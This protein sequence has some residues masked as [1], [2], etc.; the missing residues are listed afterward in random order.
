[1]Q[2]LCGACVLVIKVKSAC[3]LS[4]ADSP[5]LASARPVPNARYLAPNRADHFLRQP[6]DEVRR[7]QR[8]LARGARAPRPAREEFNF[9]C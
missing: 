9:D 5:P 8:G 3:N 6:T 7:V 1:V 4:A 2:C